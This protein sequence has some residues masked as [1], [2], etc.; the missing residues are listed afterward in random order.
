MHNKILINSYNL[1]LNIIRQVLRASLGLD[2]THQRIR[3][4]MTNLADVALQVAFDHFPEVSTLLFYYVLPI[5]I[6][7]SLSEFTKRLRF[8]SSLSRCQ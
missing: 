4:Q 5:V 8:L 6:F 1:L 3:R 7:I 2:E